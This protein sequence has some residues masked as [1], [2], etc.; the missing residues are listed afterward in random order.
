VLLALIA[1]LVWLNAGE[2]PLAGV[3]QPERALELI[4]GR[5]LDVHAAL[6]EAPAWE[7]RLYA[8]ALSDPGDE[9]DQAIAWYEELAA[10]SPVPGVDLRLAILLGEA[11]QRERLQRVVEQWRDRGEPFA[12]YAG[13]VE[14][15]YRA[16]REIDAGAVHETL[17]PLGRGWFA[18]VLALRLAAPLGEPALAG[19]ARELIAARGAA[20]LWRLRAL[21]ALDAFLLV[22]G[23]LALRSLLRRP[24][25]SGAPLPPPWSASAGVATLV[26]GGALAAVLLL[27]LL[28]AGHWLAEQPILI[29]ALDQ[30]IMHLPVLILAWRSLLAPACLGFASAF[31]LRPRPDGWGPCVRATA[32]LV[33]AGL[34]TDIG[35]GVLGVWLDLD[36]HWSE[37]FDASLVWGEPAEVATT[38]LGVVVFA[39][40]F[41]E[42]IFR[43]LIYGSLR[44]RFSWPVAAAGGAVIF[45]FAHGY[46]IAG[47]LSVFLSGILW[48]YFYERTGSLLPGMAAHVVNNAAVAVTLLALLR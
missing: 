15:A 6:A 19:R 17:G 33:A 39:P 26:R 43:G 41:E 20:L 13:V 3:E 25:V 23:A 10:W 22:L 24:V 44:S 29:G 37:W 11:G 46:G 28:A 16:G 31:G 36:P 42:L 38:V 14:A 35:L 8:L 9:I 34:V 12:T 27:L 18:D 45:G 5:T 21:V 47:F 40:L 4:V 1:L 2:P 32:V 30:L 48:A 7:R